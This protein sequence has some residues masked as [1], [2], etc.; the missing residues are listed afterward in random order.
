[1]SLLL[2]LQNTPPIKRGKQEGQSPGESSV[3]E[4]LRSCFVSQVRESNGAASARSKRRVMQ[5][6]T[7]HHPLTDARAAICPSYPAPPSLYTGHDVLWYGIALWLVGVS[8]PG[9]APSQLLVH[10][11]AGRAWETEKSL[12]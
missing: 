4:L 6:A 5:N 11:L 9:C 8:C 3:E 12:T 10:L 2:A 1:M 7:A